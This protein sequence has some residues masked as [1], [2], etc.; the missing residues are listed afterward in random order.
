VTGTSWH[1]MPAERVLAR[2]ATDKAGLPDAE[3]RRRREQFGPN[4]LPPPRPVSAVTILVNQLSSVVVLLLVAGT[5]L[6]LVM[7]DRLEAIAIAS[8]LAIN[9]ALGFTIDLSAR[10]AMEALRRL[11]QRWCGVRR[12][13]AIVRVPVEDLVPG[14]LIEIE[15]GRTVSA[16]ARLLRADDLRID[17]A[18]LTGESLPVAKDAAARLESETPMA[19]RVNMVWKGTSV[20]AG[21]GRAVVVATGRETEVGQIG[22]LLVE[23]PEERTPLERRLDVLGRRLAWTAVGVAACVASLGRLQ[24]ISVGR[25]VETAIA[26]SVAAVPEGLPAVVTIALAIGLRRM[27]VR[28]ALV[29]RLPAVEA[30]GSA[31]VVCTD[32]TR[33]LTSGAMT[34]VRIWTAGADVSLETN[35]ASPSAEVKTALEIALRATQPQAVAPHDT[36]DPVEHAIVEAALRAG[37]Q[38]SAVDAPVPVAVVPFSSGRRFMAVIRRVGTVPT[39][40]VKGAPIRVLSLCDHV[41]TPDGRRDLTLDGKARLLAVNRAMA[42][43]GLHVLAL[44]TGDVRDAPEPAVRG[45]TFVGFIGLLDPPAPGVAETIQCLRDAGLTTIMLTGDQRTTALAV[46]HRI[47]LAHDPAAVV[48]GRQ[49]D[50]MT[51][52]QLAAALDRARVFSRITPLTKLAVVRALQQRGE[53]VAML[54]DGVNDA[55]ALKK[56]DVGVTMGR[57]GSDVARDAASIVLQDDHFHTVAAAVEEGRVIYENVRKFV[58]YLFSCNLA[59]ILVVLLLGLL[60]LPPLL[61]LQILWLNLVTD[62]SPALALALEPADPDV[63]YRPPRPPRDAFLSGSAVVAMSAYAALLSAATLAA[64][65]AIDD[66]TGPRV[67]T[68][69]FVTL[70][71]AEVLHLGNA[72]SR[73]AVLNPARATANRYAL[74]AVVFTVLLQIGVMTWPLAQGVLHLEPLTGRD[75][76]VVGLAASATAVAGQLGKLVR[77]TVAWPEAAA[78][79]SRA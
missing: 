56:A 11:D 13:G 42:S 6:A 16:D 37:I 48:D 24:G 73:D 30:L 43:D 34:A 3:V 72:R 31:T 19:E 38:P 57:R 64:V 10:R 32:K 60:G 71:F 79:L 68:I 53:V 28:H 36:T 39:A 55:A 65:F 18:V 8:V 54:G 77:D 62:T 58:F 44:A 49:V 66:P 47:G 52:V 9:T 20:V 50:A 26:L 15:L 35:D 45:L 17:E 61:P 70:A 21:T 67:V 7:G 4:R 59:E 51:E 29:R 23:M 63:M 2:L 33:T 22:A 78:T 75:W 25:V 46:A 69:A 1:E 14:D 40:S 27:A 5:A 74:G 76:L 41:L 12:G